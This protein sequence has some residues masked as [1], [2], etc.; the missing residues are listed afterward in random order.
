M[1]VPCA[2]RVE[3]LRY[4]ALT[5]LPTSSFVAFYKK[6]LREQLLYTRRTQAIFGGWLKHP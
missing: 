5:R 6:N 4:D 2:S 1:H 3:F